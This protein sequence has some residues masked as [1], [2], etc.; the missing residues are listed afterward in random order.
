[1]ASRKAI[2][3]ATERVCSLGHRVAD[4]G[5]GVASRLRL[6]RWRYLIDDRLDS[7]APLTIESQACFRTDS[8]LVSL[9]G[10]A[11]LKEDEVA[12]V[13]ETSHVLEYEEDYSGPCIKRRQVE[14][15]AS[16]RTCFFEIC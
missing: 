1:M 9:W 4:R 10:D 3:L 8:S 11:F 15:D 6:N 2:D 5:V 7:G 12:E 14:T 16:F 13:V